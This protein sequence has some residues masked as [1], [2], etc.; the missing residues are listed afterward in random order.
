M[1]NPAD[2]AKVKEQ[3]GNGKEKARAAETAPVPYR[4]GTV[5]PFHGT[6][7]P[8]H[9]L[10]HEFDRL[11]DQFYRSWPASWEEAGRGWH[12]GL[13]VQ[14]TDDA[15]VVRAEAPGFEPTDFDV[16]I[17]GN[18]LVL[19]AAREAEAE[20]KERGVRE[21][22]QQ[23]FRRT[24]TLPAEIEAAKVEAHYRNGVLTVTLPRTEESK[25]HRITVHS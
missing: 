23:E 8:F 22:R 5:A 2:K 21:W 12:W 4:Q 1:A 24:V 13:D 16:Q 3:H 20:E 25:A 11:Y 6:W 19:R 14:E 10:R 7:E 15:V 17:R 9:Q 18:Q